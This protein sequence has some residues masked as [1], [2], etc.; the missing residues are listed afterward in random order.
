M[1]RIIGFIKALSCV[2]L[3]PFDD[4][5][6]IL[7][8]FSATNVYAGRIKMVKY[9]LLQTHRLTDRLGKYQQGYRK[10]AG[11]HLKIL[12]ESVILE[13]SGF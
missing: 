9:L 12:F 1:I 5:V 6:S 3:K 11:G 4:P 13:G 8:L 7:G 2:C 10:Q